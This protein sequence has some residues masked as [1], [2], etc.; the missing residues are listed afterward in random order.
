[1]TTEAQTEA[2]R[3]LKAEGGE[4]FSP[5]ALVRTEAAA[6]EALAVRLEG[7]MLP[8]FEAAVGLLLRC[9]E[10]KHRVIV[11]GV[12]KSGLIGRKIAATLC[13]TP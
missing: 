2:R 10:G 8:P 4:R 3:G 13:S 7:E 11:S 9:V 1:M 6:L 5:A 12:G